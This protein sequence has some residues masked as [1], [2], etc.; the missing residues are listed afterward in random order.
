R[1]VAAGN[2]SA[3]G[4]VRAVVAGVVP[5][6]IAA[7]GEAADDAQARGIA[8]RVR[9]AGPIAAA[10]AEGR[11]AVVAAMYSLATGVVRRLE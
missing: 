6:A 8:A 4:P 9:A 2:A 11:L 5:E 7:P 1:E 3:T 10:V